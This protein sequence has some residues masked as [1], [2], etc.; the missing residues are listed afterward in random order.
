M[1]KRQI[2]NIVNFIRGTEPRRDM[3]LYEPVVQQIRLMRE[4]GLRGTFLIQY[5]AMIQP[6]YAEL[7]KELDPSQFEIGVWMEFN[8]AHV[9]AAGLPWRG[10]FSW[11]WHAHCGFSVGYTRAER[12]K[13]VDTMFGKFR[14]IF[15][16]YPRV[17]GS[18][19][20]DTHTVSYA[21]DAYGLDAVCNCKEQYGT[22][23]YTLWGGYYGQGYYPA[24]TNVFLPAQHAGAQIPVPLFR[25]LGSDPVYQYDFG[26]NLQSGA[27]SRQ[28]VITLE[29]V[30]LKAGG[31]GDPAWVDWYLRENF[32]GECLSFG[33]AQAGQE[34]SFGWQAMEAGLR[35]Q[36]AAFARLQSEGKITVEPLGV[37][38]QWYKKTYPVTPASMITAHSAY[39]GKDKKSFWYCSRYY[40]VNWFI[41][42]D[43]LRIRDLHIFRENCEDP[44][45]NAIC[46]GNDACYESLPVLDGNRHSGRG[47]LAGI[48]LK[49]SGGDRFRCSDLQFS[50]ENGTAVL[51]GDELSIR[52]TE[53][54]ITIMADTEFTCLACRGRYDDHMPSIT[55]IPPKMLA[56]SY[57]NTEYDLHLECGSFDD[58]DTL[59]SEKKRIVLRMS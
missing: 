26:M 34:N 9:H 11:D 18:W 46:N 17:L 12:V 7:L 41:D 25:M 27:A 39:D 15:G 51:S 16:Y 55:V 42:G 21:A 49:K 56:M 52:M 40:R 57:R 6:Q 33:Y 43:T 38:G 48:Y 45:A 54:R 36:F 14:E 4:L 29:P 59:R 30:Y 37:T 19:L 22:D 24:R 23:G 8:E 10:R 35:Y 28:G 5:D 1:N 58:A 47:V 3:D 50:E 31:G 2:I 13:L 53:E 20:L 44:Y 32:S